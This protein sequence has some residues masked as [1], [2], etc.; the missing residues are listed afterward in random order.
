MATQKEKTKILFA[1][2]ETGAFLWSELL[3]GAE[4]EKLVNKLCAEYEALPEEVEMIREDVADFLEQL[5]GVDAV[6]E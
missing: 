1:L 5:R 2:N 6:E 4:E 3:A